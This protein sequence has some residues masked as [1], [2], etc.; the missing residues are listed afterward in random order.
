MPGIS[1]KNKQICIKLYRV[2]LG[3]D[4]DVWWV[5]D[6]DDLEKYAVTDKELKWYVAEDFD[7]WDDLDNVMV[8]FSF[9]SLVGN[10]ETHLF[11]RG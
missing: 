5:V 10:S 6:P 8:A 9:S 11:N 7:N 4:E 1:K 3:P 2:F